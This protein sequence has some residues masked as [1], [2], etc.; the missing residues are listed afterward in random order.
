MDDSDEFQSGN[1]CDLRHE[2]PLNPK[3]IQELH[4]F[5]TR[6]MDRRRGE[7]RFAAGVG[8]VRRTSWL[9]KVLV[10]P[11]LGFST[12]ISTND[13]VKKRG[14]DQATAEF[15]K[16][17]NN[18]MTRGKTVYVLHRHLGWGALAIVRSTQ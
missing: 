2:D 9:L 8:K 11:Y 7:L 12:S 1:T 17:W 6:E 14:E 5:F 15:D 13:G 4:D 3:A 16:S 10:A 18:T